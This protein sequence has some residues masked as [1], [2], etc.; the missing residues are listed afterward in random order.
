MTTVMMEKTRP[1][2]ARGLGRLKSPMKENNKPKNQG[3]A[4]TG[5]NQLNNMP[6][7]E[8]TKPA[9]PIPFF[10]RGGVEGC[11]AYCAPDGIPD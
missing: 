11:V 5:G 2:I 7:K 6:I 9:V 8:R 4:L 1:I 3:R 10:L